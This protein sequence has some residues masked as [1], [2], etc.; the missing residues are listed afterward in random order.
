MSGVPLYLHAGMPKTGT[1]YL[2][3][4]IFSRLP[5]FDYA[6][7]PRANILD[8]AQWQ[9]IVDAYFKRSPA[10][11]AALGG[12]L[13]TEVFG[14]VGAAPP[15]RPLLV[16]DEGVTG[17]ASIPPIQR[18]YWDRKGQEPFALHAHLQ[19]FQKCVLRY[20]YSG[21]KILLTIRRQDTK[22]ASAYA[23]VSDRIP[24]AGQASF[25]HFVDWYL[26]EKGSFY[27]GGALLDYNLL[28]EQIVAAVGED[29]FLVLPFEMLKEERERFVS[30]V[31][32]FLGQQCDH[33][34][35]PHTDYNVRKNVRSSE[36]DVWQIRRR[37][38]G[39]T[40]M[41][42]VLPFQVAKKLK[43]SATVPLCL[44]D[45]QRAKDFRMTKQASEAIL[46]CYRDS[47]RALDAKRNLGL[48]N[49]GY[50]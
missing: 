27:A 32:T 20:G 15:T 38:T 48:G 26:N 47:N 19:E 14:C 9:G 6:N 50:Y 18:F 40:R 1:T 41:L 24:G 17:G 13:F 25:E 11:W 37:A 31:H 23:Q 43:V 3:D 5:G 49:Y 21:L 2:Q 42:H 8:L 16:S 44:P 36:S 7:K 39:R 4:E 45:L 28:Y 34:G 30:K 46:A 10:I 22:L 12:R 29:N 33:T 35:L